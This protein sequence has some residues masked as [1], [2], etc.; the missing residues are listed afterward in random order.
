ML[1]TIAAFMVVLWL[2]AIAGSYTMGGW[3]HILPVIATILVIISCIHDR[4]P[5]NRKN[6]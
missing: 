3:I 2:L 5:S 1:R 4:M 6:V